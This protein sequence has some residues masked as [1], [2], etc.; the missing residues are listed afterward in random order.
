MTVPK[1]NVKLKKVSEVSETNTRSCGLLPLMGPTAY[2]LFLPLSSLSLLAKKYLTY[3]FLNIIKLD[4]FV[5]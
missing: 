1:V 4:F 3:K 5:S 2:E